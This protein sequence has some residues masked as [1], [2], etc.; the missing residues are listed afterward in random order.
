MEGFTYEY[1]PWRQVDASTFRMYGCQTKIDGTGKPVSIGYRYPEGGY[2]IRQ[3]DSK[4][5]SWSYPAG[6]SSK[7][8]LFGRD[9][10]SAGANKFITITEGELDA[11]SL[12]QVVRQPVV[13]VQS[14]SSALRDCTAD[15]SWLNSYERIYLAFDSDQPGQDACA[16]VAKLF[17]YNKVFLVKFTKYKD[18]N[19]YLVNGEDQELR[20]IW[21]NSRK[22][23]PESIISS[24]NEF[25]AILNEPE[26]PAVSYPFPCLTEMTKGIRPGEAVLVTAQEG[27]GK[28]ELMHSIEHHLL[29][30][31]D[32]AI[33]S[34]F[35]EEPKRRHLQALAG[36]EMGIP[37]HLSDNNS[38]ETFEAIKNLVG[39][40]ERLHIY[41]HFGSDDP[42]VILDTIRFLVSARA[43]KY[44]LLDHIT[45][46]CS[47]LLGDD[48]RIALDYI[49]TRLR[50]MVNE[51]N[52]ALIIVS[53]VN[54][55][56]QTRGSRYI[57]KLADIRIDLSR[58]ITSSNDRVRRTTKLVVSK[59]RFCSTTGPAGTLLFNPER[60]CLE[61]NTN[62]E[63]DISGTEELVF[64][65]QWRS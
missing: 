45:M 52:F 50:M 41:S 24:F 23:L 36:L 40:D 28:T 26:K 16:A 37:A 60:Y 46:V 3:L 53:H 62:A 13:S 51:L 31:T 7:A 1:L 47:G 34:I 30:E 61:E 4:A 39:N 19:E 49:S 29:K 32:S 20:N 63:E 22:Y 25:E 17:D 6:V 21:L 2:K 55:Q 48:E 35:L 27:V 43:C 11:V 58:D 8:G 42:D 59:N 65:Q 12:Y 57:G 10:F 15:R 54:D 38:G 44:I 5:F 14:A 33:G 56:G 18:A 64:R 9:R